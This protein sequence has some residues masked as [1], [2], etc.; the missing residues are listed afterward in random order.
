MM[1]LNR[2]LK[3]PHHSLAKHLRYTLLSSKKIRQIGSGL[4][5]NGVST[6]APRCSAFSMLLDIITLYRA[7][8]RGMFV[9]VVSSFVVP[10]NTL[11]LY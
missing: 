4:P 3:Q 11:I 1:G 6:R 2:G 5:S 8:A 9:P 7:E 10:I